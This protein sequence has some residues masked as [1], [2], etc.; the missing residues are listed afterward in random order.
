MNPAKIEKMEEELQKWGNKDPVAI[1]KSMANPERLELIEKGELR[2]TDSD[3]SDDMDVSQMD[4]NYQVDESCLEENENEEKTQTNNIGG[5]LLNNDYSP[6]EHSADIDPC[7]PDLEL[8]KN[9]WGFCDE[10]LL[11]HDNPM[12]PLSPKNSETMNESSP[13]SSPSLE[14]SYM[15]NFFV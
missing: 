13:V 4:E 1:R 12:N 8:Q 14:N 15:T 7:L 9:M 3:D 5:D 11:L 6:L 2:N 10:G